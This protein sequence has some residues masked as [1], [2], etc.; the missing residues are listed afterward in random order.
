M[1]SRSEHWAGHVSAWKES[2]L[3]QQEYCQRHGL[4]KGTMS[5]W[6]WRLKS[7]EGEQP[8]VE[9]LAPRQEPPR[10]S[11][12]AAIELEIG[13]RYLLRLRPGT[14]S[15]QLRELIGVLEQRP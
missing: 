12:P 4:V 14:D 9:L 2:G 13:G 5:H 1:G 3:S 10:G 11:E 7:L 8:I 15:E 6:V